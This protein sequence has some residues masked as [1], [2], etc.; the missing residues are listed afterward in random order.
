M[1]QSVA[2]SARTYIPSLVR[3]F[4]TRKFIRPM[5]SL[6]TRSTSAEAIALCISVGFVLG[7]F[8]VF[9][10]P[11]ALCALAAI[12]LRLNMPALQAIN[13][14]VY[15]LQIAL[16]APFIHLGDWLFRLFSS[17]AAVHYRSL[18][19]HAGAMSVHNVWVSLTHAVTAWF[20]VCVPAGFIFYLILAASLRRWR[21]GLQSQ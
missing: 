1:L 15:P 13:Y 4:W 20:F 3:E 12:V 7:L 19:E 9:G 17:P 5:R 21:R 16:L 10:V 18:V 2:F 14:L 6:A 8:P 11:T